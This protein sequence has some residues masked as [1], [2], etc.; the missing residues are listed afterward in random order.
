MKKPET[1][2]ELGDYETQD[3]STNDFPDINKDKVEVNSNTID[4][5][6]QLKNVKGYIITGIRE[7]YFRI[8]EKVPIPLDLRRAFYAP[9]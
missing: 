5:Y 6:F 2:P 3:V 7:E 8:D 4:I 1:Y 9:G